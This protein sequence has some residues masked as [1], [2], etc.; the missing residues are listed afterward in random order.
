[1]D[2]IAPFILFLLI[3]SSV[4]FPRAQSKDVLKSDARPPICAD[5]LLKSEDIRQTATAVTRTGA[6]RALRQRF[7]PILTHLTSKTGK[8]SEELFHLS[9]GLRFLKE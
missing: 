7:L 6:V 3:F 5:I 2:S 8:M 4:T 1:M 9:S